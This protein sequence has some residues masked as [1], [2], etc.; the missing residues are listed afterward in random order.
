[1]RLLIAACVLFLTVPATAREADTV[2]IATYNIEN[3]RDHF[4]AFRDR[5]KPAPATEEGRLARRV[6]RFQNDEDNWEIAQVFLDPKFDPDIV[7]F[8]EG[9]SL[10]DAKYFNREW[11][12]GMFETVVIFRSN[13]GRGQELGLLMKPGFKLIETADGFHELPD[14]GDLNPRSDRLFA[15]GPAFAL[16]ETPNGNRLWIG[17]THQKS[18]GGN[19]VEV[20]K[21]RNAEADATRRIMFELAERAP[22]MLLGDMND[23]LGFQEYE[24]EA[25]GDTMAILAGR[26]DRNPQNDLEVLTEDLAEQNVITYTGYWRDRYRSFIDHVVATPNVVDAVADVGVYDSAWARVASDHLPVWVDVIDE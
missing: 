25:G 15:R 16:V 12:D 7:V 20:T 24:K 22:V 4:Q 13:S 8:Q 14:E 19:S 11:L 23:E 6:E 18:K 2:R 1:M 26:H 21:W 10:D 9:C 3:W 5:D 17:T